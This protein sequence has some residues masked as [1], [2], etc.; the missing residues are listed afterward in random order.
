MLK[1]IVYA[2]LAAIVI[3]SCGVVTFRIF[4]PKT[5][6][7]VVEESAYLDYD[8][9]KEY[10]M[11]TGES[12]THYL[13][14]YS[15]EDND[16]VYVKNTILATVMADTQLQID[17]IIETVDITSL[18]Q[19]LTTGRLSSDWGIS[20]YPAFAAVTVADGAPKVLNVLEY[21][22]EI[23]LSAAQVEDWLRENGLITSN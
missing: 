15:R 12:V 22:G 3:Y 2:L 20:R 17:R 5:D 16:C 23:P 11:S 19:N 1:K 9:L 14:F 10:I 18:Q 7:N 21:D 8:S 13:F 6:T 4:E